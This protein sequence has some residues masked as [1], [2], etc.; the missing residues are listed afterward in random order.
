MVIKVAVIEKDPRFLDR[1]AAVFSKN[2]SDK[3]EL[4]PFTDPEVAIS[5]L[6]FVK[7]HILMADESMRI[8]TSSL[9]GDCAL[10][11]FV[12]A[13][14]TDQ[15][16]GHRAICKFQR[17]ELIYKQIVGI[18]SDKSG[19]TT[20]K[21]RG[22]ETKFITFT[23]PV[24]GV[25]VS[26]TAAAFALRLASQGHSVLYLDLDAYSCPG[27][28]FRGEGDYT[29]ADVLHTLVHKDGNLTELLV[30]ATRKDPRGVSFFRECSPLSVYPSLTPE[31]LSRLLRELRVIATFD[32]IV[33]DIPFAKFLRQ[34]DLWERSDGIVL[35]ADGTECSQLKLARGYSALLCEATEWD[36]DSSLFLLTN[37]CNTFPMRI[38]E[39]SQ[40]RDLGQIPFLSGS[41][42]NGQLSS[43][44]ALPLFDALRNH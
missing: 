14:G 18:L 15:I 43:I 36:I 29:F 38:S 7:P 16:D 20:G 25:G 3:V 19:S 24:G 8:P 5:T 33:V 26:T 27:L 35:L 30:H 11:Y 31:D 13:V 6:Q 32:Y 22:P 17:A 2:Y 44:A 41:D 1:L 40:L 12:S 23:S 34:R 42:V 28:Y 39:L 21:T 4:Y 37:K 10:A 9:P